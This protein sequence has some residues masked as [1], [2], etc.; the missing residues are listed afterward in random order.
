MVSM[1]VI[2]FHHVKRLIIIEH[3]FAYSRM[4]KPV[5]YLVFVMY[6]MYIKVV[7]SIMSGMKTYTQ[8]NY[9]NLLI[10]VC[11]KIKL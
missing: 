2:S 5:K 3:K 6:M 8:Q 1:T 7:Y 10:S 9:D 11:M 4:D